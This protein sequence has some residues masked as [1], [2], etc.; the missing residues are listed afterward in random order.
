MR[1]LS[2]S[3]IPIGREQG[4]GDIKLV[5][6]GFPVLVR[7]CDRAAHNRPPPFAFSF[8]P[9]HS[10]NIPNLWSLLNNPGVSRTGRRI[11]YPLVIVRNRGGQVRRDVAA[12]VAPRGVSSGKPG[13]P[14]RFVASSGCNVSTGP[15]SGRLREPALAPLVVLHFAVA[16]ALAELGHTEVELPHVLVLAQL[17]RRAI[18]HHAAAL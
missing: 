18:E 3:E 8:C 13:V 12:H 4:A 16:L 1:V 14:P 17:L 11:G 15:R 2:S 5:V 7:H 6:G 10:V 9:P